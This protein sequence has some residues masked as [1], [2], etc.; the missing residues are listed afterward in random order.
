M[1]LS[2]SQDLCVGSPGPG[3]GSP[4]GSEAAY[5][6]LALDLLVGDTTLPG[7]D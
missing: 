4:A 6:P 7:N 1:D 5:D 3:A 2:G